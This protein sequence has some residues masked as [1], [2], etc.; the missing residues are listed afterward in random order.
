[1]IK[2]KV[3]P[4]VYKYYESLGYEIPKVRNA[5]GKMVYPKSCE[6]EVNQKDL[7]PGSTVKVECECDYCGKHYH[8]VY[9]NIIIQLNKREKLS[10]KQCQ[11]IHIKMTNLERY[12]VE[13]SS[14]V[15][16]FK[17]KAKTTFL[18]RYG[19]YGYDV[20][21]LA[22][23][24]YKTTEEKYGNWH[25]ASTE[26]GRMK[27]QESVF[28][29]YGYKCVF[30][31]PEI[32]KKISQKMY[33]NGTVVCSS[34]QKYLYDI[35]SMQWECE[36]NYPFSNLF[37]DI[38][39]P[40]KNVYVEWDGGGHDLNVKYGNMTAEEFRIKEIRRSYFLRNRGFKELRIKSPEDKIPSNLKILE[41]VQDSL[42]YFSTGHSW[43]EYDIEKHIYRDAEHLEGAPFIFNEWNASMM[44][45]WPAEK[46]KQLQQLEF[47]SEG[48]DTYG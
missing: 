17:E 26:E 1:M 36:L 33:K 31:S 47:V 20:P 8:S 38:Y 19:G 11:S 15:D 7:S 12:G 30:S 13:N 41:I 45:T 34:Q 25:Y 35:L 4:K 46:I 40:N 9:E 21:L 28:E 29:R 48:I 37:L 42:E 44:S 14:Q 32:R 22:E 5:K 24:S 10:C 27:I 18:K 3:V 6:I 43:R 39:I 2:I 16:E 23:K